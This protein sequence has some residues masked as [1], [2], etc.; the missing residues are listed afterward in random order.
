MGAFEGVRNGVFTPDMSEPPDNLAGLREKLDEAI[1]YLSALSEEEVE[2]LRS[3]AM[4]FEIGPKRLPFTVD[5]FLLS[6]SQPN[7]YFH[8]TTA[9]GILRAKGVPLGKLDYLGALR[10]KSGA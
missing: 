3:N 6:F 9:Y 7:F 10:V 8:S 4:R 1:G 5:D 2:G